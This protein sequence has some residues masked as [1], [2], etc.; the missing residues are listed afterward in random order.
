MLCEYVCA[1]MRKCARQSF[2]SIICINHL[3][4]A[5][6]T[7]PVLRRRAQTRL[8]RHRAPPQAHPRQRSPCHSSDSSPIV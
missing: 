6:L 5:N 3:F 2:A 8:R 7:V 1:C 4:A